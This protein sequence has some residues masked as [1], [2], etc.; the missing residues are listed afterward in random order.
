[1]D[2]YRSICPTAYLTV[3]YFQ[4]GAFDLHST[5]KSTQQLYLALALWQSPYSQ[6]EFLLA[7]ITLF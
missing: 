7:L 6:I 2:T 4:T 1:M 5:L 3:L